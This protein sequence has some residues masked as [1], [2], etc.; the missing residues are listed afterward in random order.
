MSHKN[1][2]SAEDAGN[3]LA[4]CPFCGVINESCKHLVACFGV[5]EDT[6]EAGLIVEHQEEIYSLMTG[7][8]EEAVESSAPDQNSGELTATVRAFLEQH[9]EVEWVEYDLDGGTFALTNLTEGGA[10]SADAGGSIAFEVQN[11]DETVEQ[12]RAK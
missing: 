10:S 11:V 4:E 1:I 9:P 5:S 6:I 8:N 3:E 2:E 7:R 12:L